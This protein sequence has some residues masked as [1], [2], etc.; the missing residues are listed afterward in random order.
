MLLPFII[1][2]TTATQH[3]DVVLDILLMNCFTFE[4]L[5]LCWYT[6]VADDG[7][8]GSLQLVVCAVVCGLHSSGKSISKHQ[9]QQFWLRALYCR[10]LSCTKYTAVMALPDFLTLFLGIQK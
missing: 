7:H 9:Q 1:P 3:Y 6:A 10:P 4:A 2:V 5:L 8:T